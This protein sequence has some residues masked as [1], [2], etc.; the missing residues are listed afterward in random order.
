V[1]VFR[2][3]TGALVAALFSGCF[4]TQC[5]AKGIQ[6]IEAPRAAIALSLALHVLH[7]SMLVDEAAQAQPAP[8]I[9]GNFT[10]DIPLPEGEGRDQ[11][12]KICGKCYSTDIFAKEHHTRD[13]WSVILDAMTSKGMQASDDDIDLILDYLSTNFKPEKK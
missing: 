10:A 8:G 2:I 4:L 6:T 13:Q 9:P 11:A 12:R 3:G 5:E 7:R 1:K